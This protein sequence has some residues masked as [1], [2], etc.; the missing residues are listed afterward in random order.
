MELDIDAEYEEEVENLSWKE[1]SDELEPPDE[2][3]EDEDEIVL[4]DL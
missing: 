2:P 1:S 4:E 3:Q